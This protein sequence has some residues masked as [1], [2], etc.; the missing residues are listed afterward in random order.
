MRK[1]AI[2][3]A[4]LGALLLTLL[5][6]AR[7]QPAGAQS[8]EAAVSQ[9][10]LPEAGRPIPETEPPPRAPAAR[11]EPPRVGPLR[12]AYWRALGIKTAPL[13][14]RVVNAITQAGVPGAGCVVGETGDRIETDD[15]GI[16]PVIDAPIF[17]NPRLEEMLAQLHGQLTV[18]CYK[19]GYRDAIYLGVRM[20][21]G[22]TTETEIWMYPIGSGDRRIEPTL[23]QMPI[24]RL[25]RIQLADRY[26][27]FEEG[28]GPERPELTRPGELV[29]PQ[30]PQ[31]SEPQTPL[32]VDPP[33]PTEILTAP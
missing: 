4:L 33:P 18:L 16:A 26:R 30:M 8:E 13:Q 24:H 2:V 9:Q 31:G 17:R 23:Y 21:E 11:A 22:V 3:A 6:G 12:R 29:A 32:R 28:E 25:W 1:H 10:P 14:L 7:P 5:P 15:R 19:N 27:L 20:H